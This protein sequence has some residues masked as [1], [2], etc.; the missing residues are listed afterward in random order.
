[1]A[2]VELSLAVQHLKKGNIIA[3]PTETIWGLSCIASNEQSVNKIFE[4]KT[5]PQDLPKNILKN[6]I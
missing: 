2:S 4:I 3:C 1:M 5:I 6:K